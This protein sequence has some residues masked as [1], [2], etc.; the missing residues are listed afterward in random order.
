MGYIW[1]WKNNPEIYYENLKKRK[2]KAFK[3]KKAKEKIILQYSK[4]LDFIREWTYDQLKENNFNLQAIQNNCLGHTKTS[5][6]HIWKWL[7]RLLFF[8]I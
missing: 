1:L 6:G 5:Q 8:F 4:N 3:A 2:E 7:I